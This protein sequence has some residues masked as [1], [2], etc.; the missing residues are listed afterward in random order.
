MD[1]AQRIQKMIT[2]TIKDQGYE[3][4]RVQITGAKHPRLQIMAERADG[5]C[6]DVEDCATISRSISA[7]LDVEDPIEGEFTLEVSSPGIDRPLTRLQDY[8]TWAGF[9]VKIELK[10]GIDGRKRYLG[11]LLGLDEEQRILIECE[12]DEPHTLA[13]EDVQRAK[14]MLTDELIAAAATEQTK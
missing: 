12:E 7:V 2:P 9:D 6:I 3:I 8:Q 4:V 1:L 14:L 13:F 5:T 10:T 11:R